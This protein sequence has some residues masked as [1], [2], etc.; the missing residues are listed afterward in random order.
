MVSN[1]IATYYELYE[2]IYN[3]ERPDIDMETAMAMKG[4]VAKSP[5]DR[6]LQWYVTIVNLRKKR[7][8][9]NGEF[10]LPDPQILRTRNFAPCVFV[11]NLYKDDV[12]LDDS[13]FNRP[14]WAKFILKF[15]IS[16]IFR[17]SM[18]VQIYNGSATAKR[19]LIRVKSVILVN[20]GKNKEYVWTQLQ[21]HK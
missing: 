13:L 3:R 1:F 9:L 21:T 2:D 12:H 11:M 16:C 17:R 15:K 4:W 7:T 5:L 20:S 18:V 14:S 10:S 19:D 6:V 8:H